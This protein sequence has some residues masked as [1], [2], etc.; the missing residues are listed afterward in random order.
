MRQARYSFSD[1]GLR[2]RVNQGHSVKIDLALTPQ[3]PPEVL[4]HGTETR[5]LDSIRAT[6]LQP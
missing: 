2:I 1:D 3:F 4:Y 5:F 6:G